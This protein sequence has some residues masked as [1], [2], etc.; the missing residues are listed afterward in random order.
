MALVFRPFP[1]SPDEDY[2]IVCGGLVIGTLV[3]ET[4]A[5]EQVW[6]WYIH[7]V[8]APPT[9][10][11]RLSGHAADLDRAKAAVAENWQKWLVLARLKEID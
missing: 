8:N 6:R 7:G 5:R 2:D 9:G 11:V 1:H 10:N 3:K 4:V